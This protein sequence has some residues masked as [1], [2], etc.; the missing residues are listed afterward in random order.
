MQKYFSSRFGKSFARLAH[1]IP[2]DTELHLNKALQLSSYV[3]RNK[4]SLLIF[5][6]GGRSFDGELLEFK[7]GV[8]IL[9]RELN[10]PVI[11][12]YIKGTFQ[13]LPRGSAWPKYTRITVTFGNPLHPSDLDMTKKPE[14]IDAYQFFMNE[15]R[16]RV[17]L[18][19]K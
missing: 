3:L 2:I 10:I 5:P 7:K 12:A 19:S 6:E 11:P 9:S 14:G 8:G 15:V 16:E 17:E 13:A 18:L 4:K 1:V